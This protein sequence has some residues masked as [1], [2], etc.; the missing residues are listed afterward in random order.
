MRWVL[1]AYIHVYW[2]TNAMRLRKWLRRGEC[3]DLALRMS[4][5]YA[6]LVSNLPFWAGGGYAL[7]LAENVSSSSLTALAHN[8][9]L[10]PVCQ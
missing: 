9:E 5:G 6:M 7:A 10:A 4:L 3:G 2:L 1:C 8:D